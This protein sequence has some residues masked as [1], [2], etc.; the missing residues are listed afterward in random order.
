MDPTI[1]LVALLIAPVIILMALKVN[2]AIVFLSLCL[3]SVLVQ[4]VGRD[5]AAIITSGSAKTSLMPETNNY[6]NLALLLL[7]VV[8]TTVIMIHSVKGKGRLFF[9]LF[10]AVGVGV[11]TTLLAVP[12]LPKGVTNSITS[13]Q[14]WDKLDSAMTMVI[15]INTLL[16]LL[17]LWLYRPKRHHE[18]K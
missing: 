2:A 9:N 17:F 14:L 4:F 12:L 10:P 18:E 8:L 15:S 13:L 1:I 6:L 5:A 16:A 7:P 11:L 3:G